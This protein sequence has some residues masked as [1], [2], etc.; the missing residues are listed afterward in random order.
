M[1]GLSVGFAK[2]IAFLSIATFIAGW[3]GRFHF[4]PDLANHFRIHVTVA[5]LACGIWLLAFENWRLG[6][7]SLVVGIIAAVTVV[8]Y[9][10]GRPT[11]PNDMDTMSLMSFNVLTDNHNYEGVSEYILE[12]APTIVVLLEVNDEWFDSMQKRLG[13]EYPFAIERAAQ[14]NFGITMF[15]RLPFES[16]EVRTFE[17][18]AQLPSIDA[19][20]RSGDAV[21][22]V[23]GTHPLPPIPNLHWKSR[24]NQLKA[25]AEEVAATDTP[26]LVAGDMNT[27]AW[28]PCFRD[29]L[30]IGQLR[31]SAKGFGLPSTWYVGRTPITSLPIDHICVSEGV[32]VWGRKVGPDLG[33][34]HRAVEVEFSLR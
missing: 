33:S 29:L 5:A 25:I 19:T 31:D 3:L 4:L 21:F 26:T 22:R 34:D 32:D 9:F 1:A 8:P 12:R 13:D 23:I 24:N 14:D 20:F 7:A 10:F 2:L 16:V 28:S 17:D 6:G 30:R 15:S 27:T 11:K 18:M